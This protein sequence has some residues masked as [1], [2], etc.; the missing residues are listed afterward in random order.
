V[1]FRSLYAGT[2]HGIYVSFDDGARWQSLSRNLPDV[3]VSD[4]ALTGNDVVIATHGRSMYVLPNVT[5]LREMS[6]S[7]SHVPLHLFTPTV[8]T[9]N[10]DGPRFEFYLG[11]RADSVR[12][13]ILDATGKLIKTY[14]GVPADS[15][16]KP[17]KST[18]PGCSA[19]LRRDPRTPTKA[20]VNS[21][22][23]NGRYPGAAGFDCMIIW[24]GNATAG[25]MALP[26]RYQV[27][28]MANGMTET[29]PFTIR[30]DPR[31][32]GVSDEDLREQFSLAS[33]IS[34]RINDT[35]QSV[36]RIRSLRTQLAARAAATSRPDIRAA[37]TP[38]VTDLTRIEESLYQTRNRS[39]QDP[40]NFP[41]RIN[42]R[43]TALK[44]SVESGD[45]RPTAAS[46]VVFREL[47]SNLD[48]QLAALRSITDQRIPAINKLLAAASE[49]PIVDTH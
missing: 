39:G 3:Q 45:S 14:T 28:V 1:L 41:I 13:D 17:A 9:R 46:F 43:L 29:K 8:S 35:N 21:F 2:E 20:G 26:G 34:A 48:T 30:K 12:I 37:I 25:P 5:S 16:I 31:L 33:K 10:V 36:I 38:V 15:A 24:G 40:L 19:P 42:D 49:K 32:I 47:S 44:E 23:W 11:K 7:L 4:I 27:R 6:P 22:S 18:V